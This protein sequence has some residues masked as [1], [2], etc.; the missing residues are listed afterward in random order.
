[1]ARRTRSGW[2]WPLAA[3]AVALL[4]IALEL[5]AVVVVGALAA[6]MVAVLVAGTVQRKTGDLAVDQV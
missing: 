3:A 4:D 2:W 1:M 5:P 6:L